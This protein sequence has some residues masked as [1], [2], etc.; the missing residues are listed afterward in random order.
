MSPSIN[1]ALRFCSGFDNTLRRLVGEGCWLSVFL[2][3]IVDI[4]HVRTAAVSSKAPVGWLSIVLIVIPGDAPLPDV[5]T[6][7]R[8]D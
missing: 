8:Q 6:L 3:C 4:R 2:P 1:P 7:L 5:F